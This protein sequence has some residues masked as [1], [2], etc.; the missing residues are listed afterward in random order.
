MKPFLYDRLRVS[1][2]DEVLSGFYQEGD[3]FLSNRTIRRLW[4]V[5][6]R[7][8][9]RSI[10]DLMEMGVLTAHLRSG[11]RLQPS[12]RHTA[13]LVL[14][15]EKT[16]RWPKEQ[17]WS[18]KAVALRGRPRR[19]RRW[20]AVFDG[21]RL[22]HE[23]GWNPHHTRIIEGSERTLMNGFHREA[24]LKDEEVDFLWVPAEGMSLRRLDAILARR[25]WDGVAFFRRTSSSH[26][27]HAVDAFFQKV[28]LPMLTVFEAPGDRR[29]PSI[30]VNDL[31]LGYEAAQHLLMAGAERIVI[32]VNPT[33][34]FY[35]QE[36]ILG[37]R[38]RCR[39]AGLDEE[40]LIIQTIHDSLHPSQAS[41]IRNLLQDGKK[42]RLGMLVLNNQL[43]YQMESEIRSIGL[44]IPEQLSVITCGSKITTPLLSK[45]LPNMDI[46][47]EKMAQD[48]FQALG[49]LTDGIMT[50]REWVTVSR[51]R[52]V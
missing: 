30:R 6:Q 1:L 13:S 9:D 49:D 51:F 2:L 29:A 43:F 18:E 38:L 5:N 35:H 42:K 19:K 32:L 12:Y 28:S 48:T 17:S 4:G 24:C 36:R 22:W 33:L 50:G 20:L 3:R 27:F 41:L 11:Y 47:F 39:Q 8:V 40:N 21:N 37:A 34:P 7:T 14:Q 31:G 46:G 15:Q 52:S 23:P 16:P 25:L 45:T 10:T 26:S 44:R